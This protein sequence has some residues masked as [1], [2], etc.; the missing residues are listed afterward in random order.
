MAETAAHPTYPL[1]FSEWRIRNTAVAN[2]VVFAPTCP[3]WVADPHE[4]VFTDQAV[5]YYEER[6]KA[7]C[8]LIIIGGT[9][10]HRRRSTRSSTS[11]AS[12][13]TSR[14]R[15]CVASPMPSTPRLQARGA[16][17]ARRPARDARAEEGSGV[18]L[19]RGVVHGRAEPGSARRVPERADAQGARGAR[20]RGHPR[21]V[22]R[23]CRAAA[24]DAGLDG[25]EFHMS[26]GYLPWQFLSPLYNHRT[27]RWGGSYENR[28]RFPLEAL[29]QDSGGDRRRAVP[30]LPDQLDLLLAGRPRDGRRQA[31]RRRPRG[32]GATSTT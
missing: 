7:G 1:L 25:V 18:R 20:D 27:D 13:T 15:A 5:A 16:A 4:G 31:H 9:V 11:P 32:E 2:R 23:G 3:T 19:R 12:G 10:I 14:S 28:L 8:G 30:R 21:G 29:Q 6:A 24:I 17:A 26:H 22:R